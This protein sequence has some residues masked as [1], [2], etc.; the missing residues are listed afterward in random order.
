MF[1]EL[2]QYP[3]RAGKMDEWVKLMDDVIIPF[4]R[5]V[6]MIVIGSFIDKPNNR[7]VWIRRFENQEEKE[8]LYE[9][10]YQNDFWQNEMSPKVGDYIDRDGIVVDILTA[11]PRSVIQ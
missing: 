5:S 7:Y 4:Q 3:V 6:G 9:A 10:A 2:R 1:F 11:T 8:A